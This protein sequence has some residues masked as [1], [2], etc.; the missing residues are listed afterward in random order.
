MATYKGQ[1]SSTPQDDGQ[2]VSGWQDG[3]GGPVVG[4][5]QWSSP[6]VH[7]SDFVEALKETGGHPQGVWINNTNKARGRT[8]VCYAGQIS[9]NLQDDF[10]GKVDVTP[11]SIAAGL[12]LSEQNYELVVAN[13]YKTE[14]R[15]LI[16]VTST[17]GAGVSITNLPGL[18]LAMP[19]LS[20]FT[21][22]LEILPDGP[23][24]INGELIFTFDTGQ[25]TVTITGQRSIIFGFQPEA[26]IKEKLRWNTDILRHRDGTEQRVSLRQA[27]R[28]VVEMDFK[29]SGRT[30]QRYEWLMAD[31]Q[32][33]GLGVPIWWEPSI[34]TAAVAVDDTSISVDSTA[35]A[36]YKVGGLAVIWESVEKHETLQI[37]SIAAGSLTFSSGFTNAY[38]AG[39]LVMPMQVGYLLQREIRGAKHPVNLSEHRLI[40]TI[41]SNDDDLADISAWPTFNSKVIL[42]G[43]GNQ[44][45]LPGATTPTGSRRRTE[46]VDN[47]TGVFDLYSQQAISRQTGRYQ[48]LVNSRQKL[49]EVRQLLHA[50]RGQQVSFYIPT[51]ADDFTPTQSIST[52]G[53]VITVV[54]S[55]FDNFI[56]AA[57][58]FDA[59]LVRLTD[60]TEITR[61]LTSSLEV[62]ADEEQLFISGTWGVDATPAEID[63]VCVVQKVR[64]DSDEVTITH[65]DGIGGATISFPFVSVLD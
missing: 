40:F 56:D 43:K 6:T 26:P 42:T 18:P 51:Y 23:T 17:A 19:A 9:P 21:V 25:E 53:N 41:N 63:F 47:G 11:D 44:N 64:L 24:S 34:S 14:E 31:S 12:I 37:D 60:G 27:P 1:I 28:Q 2:R 8:R 48:L 36:D 58:P 57:Q 35:Y 55:G 45:I 5:V 13:Y 22:N 61:A 52:A 15:T 3:P 30:R 7:G 38:S 54:N 50:L 46:R 29:L 10:F 16:S 20:A 4:D 62:D 65:R 33:L 49:W 32:A 39:V 59:V